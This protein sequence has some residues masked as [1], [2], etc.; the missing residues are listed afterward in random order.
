MIILPDEQRKII[1][2][3]SVRSRAQSNKSSTR[4]LLTFRAKSLINIGSGD[5]SIK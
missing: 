4:R 3:L 5:T 2:Y 1:F